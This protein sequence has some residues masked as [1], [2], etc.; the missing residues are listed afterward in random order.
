MTLIENNHR[1]HFTY[2][3]EKLGYLVI[4][5]HD[6]WLVNCGFH[7][8]MLNIAYGMPREK[9]LE[10]IHAVVDHFKQQ[11]FA[12]WILPSLTCEDF[13][14]ILLKEG[15]IQEAPEYA[16]YYSLKDTSHLSV[17]KTEMTIYAIK[18]QENRGDGGNMADFLHILSHYDPNVSAFF[19][20]IPQHDL[21]HGSE[22]FFVGYVDKEPVCIALMYKGQKTSAIFS[23]IT[24]E[25]QR[26]QGYGSHM[27]A[28]MLLEAKKRGDT[29]VTLSASGDE[30]YGL[31]AKLGFKNVGFFHCFEWSPS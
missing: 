17:Y 16:M 10:S 19:Q 1:E 6:M 22:T 13:N 20:K 26:R 27:M 15:F 7:T 24:P 9:N 23:L 4:E 25:K 31:Y 14:A 12:W 30:A 2:F 5:K 28:H 21:Q 8:S 29:Y 18:Y 3:P 11:P